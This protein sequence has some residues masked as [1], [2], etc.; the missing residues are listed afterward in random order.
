MFKWLFNRLL[1]ILIM[2]G[3]VKLRESSLTVILA[4]LC[5]AVLVL[6]TICVCVKTVMAARTAA[7]EISLDT[8]ALVQ[9]IHRRFISLP[10]FS[11]GNTDFTHLPTNFSHILPIC[12][13]RIE[14]KIRW[15]WIVVARF[16]PAS[17]RYAPAAKSSNIQQYT[18]QTMRVARS[19]SI[20]LS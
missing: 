7:L 8:A 17:S 13:L 6:V 12:S 11:F 1:I 18:A 16:H 14:L 3:T 19:R 15:H 10:V 20:L 2:K 4:V 9:S 5:C